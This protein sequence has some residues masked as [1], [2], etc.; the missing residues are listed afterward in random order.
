MKKKIVKMKLTLLFLFGTLLVSCIASPAI[1]N[2]VM[3]N[4]C[5]VNKNIINHGYSEDNYKI[6]IYI[7]AA[8]IQIW[9]ILINS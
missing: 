6:V 2:T 1:D 8:V 3:M 9:I 5:I 4:L 7:R